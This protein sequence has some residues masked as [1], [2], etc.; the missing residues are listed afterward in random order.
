[1]GFRSPITTANAVDTGGGV[2]A[3]IVVDLVH[4]N[5]RS[6]LLSPA[7]AGYL[8]NA[9]LQP[10]LWYPVDDWGGNGPSLVLQ[11]PGSG[12]GASMVLTD[13]GGTFFTGGPVSGLPQGTIVGYGQ[14]TVTG[15]TTGTAEQRLA[16]N[17]NCTVTLTAGRA[18]E[19]IFAGR[20]SADTAPGLIGVHL[21]AALGA[22]PTTSSPVVA[23]LQRWLATSGG[24]GQT[25]AN[26]S[27]QPFQVTTSGSYTISPFGY[28][29]SG[30]STM[31][32]LADARGVYSI[33]VVDTGPAPATLRSI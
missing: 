18:Y 30:T 6:Q 5:P 21:R 23:S 19:A 26:N 14:E 31:S 3:R 28:V 2:G 33:T 16:G 9:A 24:P 1:M 8:A 12:S 4:T 27:G 7:L 10:G 17:E 32:V 22:T 15:S 29:A 20:L 11:A 25:D 13:A